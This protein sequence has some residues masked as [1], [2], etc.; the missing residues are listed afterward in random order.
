MFGAKASAQSSL[1]KVV[2]G[3][4]PAPDIRK[5]S[6]PPAKKVEPRKKT[7]AKAPPVAK[8]PV[9]TAAKNRSSGKSATR[10]PS[11]RPGWINVTFESKDPDTM[12]FLN[13]NHVGTTDE[14]RTFRRTITPGIYRVKGVVGSSV[15]FPE[16]LVQLSTDK[17]SVTVREEAAKKEPEKNDLPFVIPKTQ[18]EIEMEL[19]REMSAKVIKIF[20]D[21][22]DPQKSADITT[23][24]WRFAANA[25]VLGEFQNL[26]KQQIEAQRKFAAGQIALA[27]GNRQKAFADFNLAVQSFPSSPLPHIGLGDAYFA[28]AQWQDARRTYEQARRFGA[29]F[30]MTHLRLGDIYRILGDKKKAVLSYA[31]AIRFGDTRYETRFLRARALVDIDD[32]DA[33]IPLLEELL[34]E[35]TT[36]VVYVALGEAYEMRK[37][38]VAALDNY[39]K[40]VELDPALP[41]AQYRLA[42]IYYEQREYQKAVE[43]FDAALK[44]D[45]DRRSFSHEDAR[46]KRSNASV[47]IRTV[48][49]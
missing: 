35:K 21:F 46:E 15:V 36:S 9:G 4:T 47:R 29:N 48:S 37:R 38:E 49:K 3:S 16:K 5:P 34:K 22:M 20:A 19:A 27:E 26:S 12:I 18:A 32:M 10:R 7:V 6:P 40:A 44:L 2:Y 43:G 1:R 33:A 30:W 42:R 13:G 17:M 28:S 31:D 39:R 24:D 25:A 23:D 11:T 14:N 45:G 8:K 41:V